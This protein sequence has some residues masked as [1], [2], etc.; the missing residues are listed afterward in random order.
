M[1]FSTLMIM[2]IGY[3]VIE[4][5]NCVNVRFMCSLKIN[6]LIQSSKAEF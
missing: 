3:E 2:Y 1:P 6:E 5:D 4:D